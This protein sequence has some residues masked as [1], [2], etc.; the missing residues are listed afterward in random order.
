MA[1]ADYDY[2]ATEYGGTAVSLDDFPFLSNKASAYIDA[3]TM[4]RAKSATGEI[5]DAVKMAMCA[6][7]DVFLD[8]ENIN[9]A[10]CS[11]EAL[12]ASL[13]SETVGRWTKSYKTKAVSTADGQVLDK[14]KQDA[15]TMY[16]GWTG[17]LNSQS[18][19][20]RRY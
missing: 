6:L 7:T 19:Y 11:E 13:S 9:A 3:A 16:L 18:Y 20:V 1:Y 2:Y 12:L 4:R 14:R 5:L 15:L 8:E 17:L 10:T